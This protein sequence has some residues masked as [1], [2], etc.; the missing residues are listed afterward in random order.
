MRRILM[1]ERE[2]TIDGIEY[3]ICVDGDGEF[4]VERFTADGDR[5]EVARTAVPAAHLMEM[6]H[7][8]E[9]AHDQMEYVETLYGEEPRAARRF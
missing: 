5:E 9:D 6:I 8:A 1:V 2:L 3:V 7:A 4:T